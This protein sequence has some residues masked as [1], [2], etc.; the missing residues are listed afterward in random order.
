MS[1]RY[2]RVFSLPENLYAL[3]SPVVISAGAL[4]K[5]NQTGKVLAQLKLT[6]IQYKKIKAVKVK[7]FPRDTMGQPLGEAIDYQYLDLQLTRDGDFGAKTPIPFPDTTTRAFAVEV[8]SVVFSD[9]TAWNS[10]GGSWEPIPD[11]IP[12]HRQYDNLVIEQLRLEQSGTCQFVVQ[13]HKDLWLC[14]CGAVNYDGEARCHDCGKQLSRIHPLDIEGLTERA[15]LRLAEEA[16]QA[17]EE[18]AAR[19]ATAEAAK[20]K[21]TQLLKILIPVVC[22]IAVFVILLWGVQWSPSWL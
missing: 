17:A 1:E 2:T 12:L 7:L 19:E 13:E 18:K 14:T 5:D 9:N 22:V 11:N 3:G 15:N 6:N 8:S 4:L 16:R 21:R 20:K 10:D